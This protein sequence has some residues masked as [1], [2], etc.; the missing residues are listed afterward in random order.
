MT[1][2]VER[3]GLV[4]KAVPRRSYTGNTQVEEDG[5]FFSALICPFELWW[6]RSEDSLQLRTNSK[7]KVQCFEMPCNVGNEHLLCGQWTAEDVCP[8]RYIVLGCSVS[9]LENSLKRTLQSIQT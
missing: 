3:M 6:F 8:H 4:L 1:S 7:I 9:G 2:E 5:N